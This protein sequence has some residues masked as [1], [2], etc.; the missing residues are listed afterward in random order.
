MSFRPCPLSSN[1]VGYGSSRQIHPGCYPEITTYSSGNYLFNANAGTVKI[2]FE[3]QADLRGGGHEQPVQ[4]Y[5]RGGGFRSVVIDGKA[6]MA[7]NG[8]RFNAVVSVLLA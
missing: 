2:E 7:L 5:R 1:E 6:I 4:T 8:G 3:K